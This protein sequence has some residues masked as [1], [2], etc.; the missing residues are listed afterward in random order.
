VAG[1][2]SELKSAG[3]MDNTYVIFTSDN[4]WHEGEHRIPRYKWRPYEEDVSMPLL[5][6]GPGVT[7]GHDAQELALNTDF[8][9]TFTDLACPSSAPCDTQN[10]T[11][12]PDGRSL[13]PVLE[14]NASAWRSSVLLEAAEDSSPAYYGIRTGG[15]GR[16]Y[17]E[18]EGGEKELYDLGTD[19]YELSNTYD[20]AAPP[21]DLTTRLQA[22]KTCAGD[23]CRAAEDGP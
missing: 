3:V 12:V 19:P 2:L 22:L 1:V 18:Y 21:A 14:G 9:P 23:S 15:S 10:W 13:R 20:P 7:A 11:Y 16:K 6:R 5:V 8:L 4:G 17:V